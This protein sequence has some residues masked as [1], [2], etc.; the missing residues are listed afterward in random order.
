[1]EETHSRDLPLPAKTH[2][3]TRY[4]QRILRDYLGI[5]G[6]V[7]LQVERAGAGRMSEKVRVGV[8]KIKR[9]AVVGHG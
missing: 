9:V 4:R 5:M 1:M 3:R 7:F 2:A 8:V 6:Q